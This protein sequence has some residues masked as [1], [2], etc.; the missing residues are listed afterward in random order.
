MGTDRVSIERR[1]ERV[2][3]HEWRSMDR[4]LAGI[5]TTTLL[6]LREAHGDFRY[7]LRDGPRRMNG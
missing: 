6:L 4:S 1:F 5:A 3:V 2:S 7:L